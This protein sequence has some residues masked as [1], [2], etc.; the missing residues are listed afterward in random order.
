MGQVFIFPSLAKLST[1][2]TFKS[3]SSSSL[4]D[5][6]SPRALRKAQDTQIMKLPGNLD[7]FSTFK[8]RKK[9]QGG[10]ANKLS[11]GCEEIE[12]QRGGVDNE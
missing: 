11:F 6:L 7:N 4:E 9:V 2:M 10:C 1:G 12:E 3:S 8:L 5:I